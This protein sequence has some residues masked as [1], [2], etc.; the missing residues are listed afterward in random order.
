MAA[1]IGFILALGGLLLSGRIFSSSAGSC[2]ALGNVLVRQASLFLMVDD[3]R[4]VCVISI[5]AL[6]GLLMPASVCSGPTGCC[7]ALGTASVRQSSSFTVLGDF[8]GARLGFG[9]AP[10]HTSGGLYLSILSN[11]LGENAE[12][13]E[14]YYFNKVI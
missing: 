3:G 5:L 8:S 1:F 13:H 7:S 9:I 6:G 11:F 12:K 10:Y 14:R 2:L 4:G